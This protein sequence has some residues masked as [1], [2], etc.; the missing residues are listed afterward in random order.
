MN[1]S[2]EKVQKYFSQISEHVLIPIEYGILERSCFATTMLLFAAVDGLGRL[3]HPNSKAN[4]RKRFT[5]FISTLGKG[6][7]TNRNQLWKLRCSLMHNALNS[8]TMLA[9]LADGML[10]HLNKFGPKSVIYVNTNK[11]LED[12]KNQ[13]ENLQQEILSNPQEIN[14]IGGR[15]ELIKIEPNNPGFLTYT[16]ESDVDFTTSTTTDFVMETEALNFFHSFTSHL[17]QT[18]QKLSEDG[19]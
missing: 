17:L 1:D 9:F 8:G 3:I 13:F 10:E 19:K 5:Y 6:Y 16:P 4:P 7:K 12:F 18:F 2:K 11:L 14:R 15:L